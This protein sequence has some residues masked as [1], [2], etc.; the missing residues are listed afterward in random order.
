MSLRVRT[1]LVQ[2][3]FIDLTRSTFWTILTGEAA[4]KSGRSSVRVMERR[5]ARF[6]AMASRAVL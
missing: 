6:L 3:G 5:M 2:A 1:R 4:E